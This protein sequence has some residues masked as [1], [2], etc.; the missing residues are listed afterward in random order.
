[1]VITWQPVTP[2]LRTTGTLVAYLKPMKI[3]NLFHITNFDVLGK[4]VQFHFQAILC[5]WKADITM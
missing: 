2:V 4:G 1:M 3:L 5:H